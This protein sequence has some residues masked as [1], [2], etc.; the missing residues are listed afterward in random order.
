MQTVRKL[1]FGCGA[2]VRNHQH[3][4]VVLPKYLLDFGSICTQLCLHTKDVAGSVVIVLVGC[5]VSRNKDYQKYTDHWNHQPA[6]QLAQ[7][8]TGGNQLA[9]A[10]FIQQ[11]VG[12]QNQIRHKDKDGDQAQCN[13]LCQCQ[14]KVRS[15]AELHQHQRQKSDNGGQTTGKDGCSGFHQGIHHCR[16]CIRVFQSA[17]LKAVNQKDRIIQRNRQLE[18]IACC[19]GNKGNPS[20]NQV[21]AAVDGDCYPQSAQYN[22]RLNPG[23]GGNQENNQNKQHGESGNHHNLFNGAGGCN[24][25]GNRAAGHRIVFSNQCANI[26]YCLNPLV[27]INRHGKQR[28]IVL[29]IGLQGIPVDGIQRHMNI[30][31]IIQPGHLAH[32]IYL[33]EFFFILQR[34]RY[35]Q[36][37][38]HHPGVWNPTFKLFLH[39]IQCNGGGR[40][41]RQVI[42]DVIIDRYQILHKNTQYGQHQK[43]GQHCLGMLNDP[44]VKFSHCVFSS[45]RGRPVPLSAKWFC[46]LCSSRCS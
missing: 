25:G 32:T 2:V 17:L 44:L 38:D 37:V 39:H 18:D 20:E 29:V 11:T 14:S 16:F 46:L 35:R 23:R 26:F 19:I 43:C 42:V 22:Q 27:F 24:C 15:D 34:L 13:A 8:T 4:G 6:H 7:A 30:R 21:G 28:C 3:I 12:H 45:L 36:V 40:I 5:Q 33:F 9:M 10:G 41:L 31:R 1:L